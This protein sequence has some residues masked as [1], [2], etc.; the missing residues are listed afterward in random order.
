MQHLLQDLSQLVK[1]GKADLHRFAQ[2]LR[3]LFRK[4]KLQYHKTSIEALKSDL[5]LLLSTLQYARGVS[6]KAPATIL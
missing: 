1:E 3:W 2:R 4:A 5:L 6:E